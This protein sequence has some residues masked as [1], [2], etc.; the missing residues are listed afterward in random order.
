[1]SG[2]VGGT[3][4]RLVDGVLLS[5]EGMGSVGVRA[6]GGRCV[7]SFMLFPILPLALSLPY[8]VTQI[9]SASTGLTEGTHR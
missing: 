1:M 8:L 9:K 4:P 7:I 3:R 5:R 2:S 6:S